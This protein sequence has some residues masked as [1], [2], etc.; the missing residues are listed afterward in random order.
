MAKRILKQT[1]TIAVVKVSGTNISETITLATDLLAPTMIVDGTPKVNI[2]YTQWNV[3]GGASDTVTITRGGVQ[4]LNL[5]QNAGELDMGG[6]GGF[7]D[8]TNNTSDLV[9]T[10]VG[11]ANVYLT[12]R[13]VDGYASKIETAQ[14]GPYDNTTAVGS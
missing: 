3:S 5:F 12:L 10:I 7:A 13:K 8:D 6:N 14:F 9:C 11:T 1:E 2:I 4:V